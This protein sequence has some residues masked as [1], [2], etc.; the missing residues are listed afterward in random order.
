MNKWLAKNSD[1]LV[2]VGLALIAFV[3]RLWNLGHLGFRGDEDLTAIAVKAVIEHGYPLLDS[4][5]V[6]PRFLPLQYLLAEWTA[7]FGFSEGVLRF[8]IVLFGTAMVPIV[9]VITKDLVNSKTAILAAA[10]IA[11]DF[12]QVELSRNARM[13]APFFVVFGLY[14]IA[15]YRGGLWGRLGWKLAAFPLGLLAV[16]LFQVGVLGAVL[17]LVPLFLDPDKRREIFPYAVFS[18]VVLAF[19]WLRDISATMWFLSKHDS[20]ADVSAN[21][22]ILMGVS[23]IVEQVLEALAEIV[24]V[25]SLSLFVELTGTTIGTLLWVGI[26]AISIYSAARVGKEGGLLSRSIAILIAVSVMFH[27]FTVAFLLVATYAGL[28]K[29]GRTAFTD[30]DTRALTLLVAIVLCLWMIY[31][32]WLGYTSTDWKSVAQLLF[33]YPRF[34]LVWAQPIYR[35]LMSV[36]ALVGLVVL[37]DR[38]A[39][40]NGDK[41]AGMLILGLLCCYGLVGVFASPYS[42]FRYVVH[43]DIFFVPL[44]ATGMLAIAESFLRLTR[45]RSREALGADHKGIQRGAILFALFIVMVVPIRAMLSVDREYVADSWLETAMRLGR[46]SD[47]KTP[48]EY[49]VANRQPG[50]QILTLEPRE[51]YNY[52]G[53]IDGWIQSRMFEPQAVWWNGEPHDRYLGV[54]ILQSIGEVTSVINSH[55]GRTWLPFNSRIL[56][57]NRRGVDDEIAEFLK[58][59]MYRRKIV[60]ADETTVVLLFE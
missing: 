57:T 41:S 31:S 35:P 32:F 53:S 40:P 15:V 30:T 20:I 25:P 13:Y 5:M 37:F 2:V 6:Y 10:I 33:E 60:A 28:K 36:A 46:Y 7:L 11:F 21:T 17:V 26:L 39:R 27:Q 1:L 23:P 58:A 49:I 29:R 51:Y 44:V 47:F 54:P 52:L 45:S 24:F 14:A 16:S 50:D 22:P 38:W 34:R 4:G 59:N 9:Y 19:L 43:A 56:S 8:P 55:E 42:H 18:S 48:S 12:W 3:L